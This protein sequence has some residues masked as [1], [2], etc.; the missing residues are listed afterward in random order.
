M[1]KFCIHLL[2]GISF[3]ICSC[4]QSVP[5]V[6]NGNLSNLEDTTITIVLGKDPITGLE[7]SDYQ[8][9]YEISEE[10]TFSIPLE[11]SY[12]ISLVMFSENHD[13]FARVELLHGGELTLIA[14]CSDLGETLE[15]QGIN[16]DLNTFYH[17]WDKF[18]AKAIKEILRDFV[19]FSK[20]ENSLDSLQTISLRMLEEYRSEKNL[21]K[22][23]L[24]W[25]SSKITYGKYFSMMHRAYEMNADLSDSVF[26][27]FQSINLND[28]DAS[29]ISRTYNNLVLRY[30]LYEVN[31]KGIAYTDSDDKLEYFKTFYKTINTKL[32]GNVRDAALT[33]LISDMLKSYN[34]LAEAYYEFYLAD[35][36]S[37]KMVEK[38]RELNV[39]Y[40]K[41]LNA[42]LNDS[43]N[44]IS[45][46]QQGPG[47]VLHQ[48]EN[49]VVLLDFWAS[50]CSPCIRGM[51]HTRQLAEHYKDQNLVVLFV[52]NDDQES[53][54]I[55]AIKEHHLLGN[56]IIL[57]VEESNIWG[58]EFDIK[59]L[60]SYVLID[61]AGNVVDLD[62][63]HQLTEDTYILIDSLL[64][65]P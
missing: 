42:P 59:G 65:M 7:L 3:F 53:S 23:E 47:E 35:C 31:S 48:F 49:E 17:D 64:S 5:S 9:I 32:T 63:P 58:Q 30:V 11:T 13:F 44:M 41:I 39:D 6:V 37:P 54:L 16:A 26:Q 43:V 45:T 61:K 56:H 38:T 34:D 57:N 20:F 40:L 50:W 29:L 55:N 36:K 8:K 10:G 28:Q 52:G 24:L 51:P 19:S 2:F 33:G 21:S 18:D 60:P 62:T 4:T 12:P 15:Y 46:H 27:F 1:Y 22:E 25:L 14:D